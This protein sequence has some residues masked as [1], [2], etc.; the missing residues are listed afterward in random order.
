VFTSQL[1]PHLTEYGL[2]HWWR[3]LK[4]Y[5]TKDQWALIGDVTFH[6]LCH[7]F[8]H[9]ARDAGCAPSSEG[10]QMGKV[11]PTVSLAL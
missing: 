8:A 5:A 11:P 9:R 3:A 1:S 4:Q 2:H 6:D 7:D 10:R